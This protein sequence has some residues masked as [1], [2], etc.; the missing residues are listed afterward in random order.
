MRKQNQRAVL[1]VHTYQMKDY[2]EQQDAQ[3]E[4]RLGAQ[5][6]TLL[7]T[8]RDPT[9]LRRRQWATRQQHPKGLED[10]AHI[11]GKLT[12]PY[13][14]FESKKSQILIAHQKEDIGRTQKSSLVGQKKFRG[15]CT[16]FLLLTTQGVFDDGL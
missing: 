10:F 14:M 15:F 6:F 3:I 16:F 4:L 12:T 1:Y 8:L 11:F 9:Q 13:G 2:P 7:N 5:S